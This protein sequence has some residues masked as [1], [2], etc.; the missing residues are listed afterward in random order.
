MKSRAFGA[1]PDYASLHPGYG[2]QPRR[3]LHPP[4][5]RLQTPDSPA[6]SGNTIPFVPGT[7]LF[8]ESP[9]EA[10]LRICRLGKSVASAFGT[11]LEF[12]PTEPGAYR[13]EGRLDGRAWAF[14]N[15]VRL[16]PQ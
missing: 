1:A 3:L 2:A 8:V 6:R 12:E 16:V 13:A 4:D 15:H 5:S 7:E 11:K 14:S 9:V 10:E